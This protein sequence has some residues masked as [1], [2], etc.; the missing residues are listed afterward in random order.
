MDERTI[1]RVSYAMAGGL[2]RRQILR[3][4]GGGATA[5]ALAVAGLGSVRQASAQMAFPLVGDDGANFF[6]GTFAPTEFAIQRGQVVGTGLVTGDL[7]DAAVGGNLIGTATPDVLTL[8][9]LGGGGDGT[10]TILELVLGPL[11]LNLLGLEVFLDTVTLIITANPAGG[12][13]GE[14]LCAIADLLSGP[15]NALGR[16]RNLLN[17]LLGVLNGL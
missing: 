17:Q 13:L 1:D 8:P 2:S 16:L 9:I 5:G 11:D 4:L 3:L 15:G 12:L 14:L 10:C 7:F 6:R